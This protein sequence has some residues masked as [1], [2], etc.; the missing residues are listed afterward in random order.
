MTYE[1]KGIL[2]VQEWNRNKV[3]DSLVSMV[4]ECGGSWD[5]LRERFDWEF[6]GMGP[7]V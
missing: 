3:R 2:V 1:I 5:R 6:E 7:R 4:D